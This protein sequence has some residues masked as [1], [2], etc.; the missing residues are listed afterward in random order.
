[1]KSPVNVKKYCYDY[2]ENRKIAAMLDKNQISQLIKI[3]GYSKS[4]VNYVLRG[5]RTN[6]III[7]SALILIAKTNE[8]NKIIS[9]VS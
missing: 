8:V 4:Y 2:P 9:L 6:D 1:M 7:N 3:S 5:E